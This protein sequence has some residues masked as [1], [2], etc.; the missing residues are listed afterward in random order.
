MINSSELNIALISLSFLPKKG[1]MEYVVHD[2]ATT[3]TDLGHRVYVFAPRLRKNE[4]EIN[5]NYKLIRFGSKIKGAYKSG[6]NKYILAYHFNAVH[7]KLPFDIIN[8]HSAYSSTDYGLFLKK[9]FSVP[10]VI[11]C[12]GHDIQRIPEINYGYRLDEK[13][14]NVICQNIIGSDLTVSISSAVY[15]ELID[16]IPHGKIRSIP[17]GI[18]LPD[19]K[20]FQKGFLRDRLSI[21]DDPIIISVGRNHI[22]K[23]FELGLLTF[24]KVLE[25]IPNAKYVHVGKD[26][27][28]LVEFARK[29]KVNKSFFAIG[30]LTRENVY[31]SYFDSDLFFSPAQVESFG[32]VTY[33]AMYFKLP[34]VVSNGPGNRDAIEDGENGFVVP[35]GDID[36]NSEA[37]LNILLNDKLKIL[38]GN[39]AEQTIYKNHTWESAA[40]QYENMFISFIRKKIP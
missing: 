24:Q 5:H 37:I 13:M 26:S 6:F 23:S 12:H 29:I 38:F 28:S 30:E 15:D 11:T 39:R 8:S 17:N 18:T 22:K 9:L 2:L 7:R 40:K 34:C 1:G 14:N 36:K 32:L 27:E 3:L 25:K 19:K 10:V 33:E 35:F 31:L 4:E 20:H 16:I 21:G